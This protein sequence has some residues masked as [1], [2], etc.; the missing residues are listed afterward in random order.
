MKQNQA[1]H[2]GAQG[3]KGVEGVRK[4]TRKDRRVGKEEG[5][6]ST[7]RKGCWDTSHYNINQEAGHGAQGLGC[8]CTGGQK[9]QEDDDGKEERGGN[10]G[11]RIKETRR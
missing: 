2:S 4:A 9:P 8:P 3:A 11:R 6:K 5:R 1:S 7:G 10:K